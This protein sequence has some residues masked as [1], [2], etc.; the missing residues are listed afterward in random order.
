VSAPPR[1]PVAVFLTSFDSGGTERQMTE[2]IRRLDRNTF[3]VHVACFH[4]HG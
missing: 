2:L 4:R 1:I 3:D